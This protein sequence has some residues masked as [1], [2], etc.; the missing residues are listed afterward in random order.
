[1]G[2]NV[3]L[4]DY[5]VGAGFQVEANREGGT[6]NEGPDFVSLASL[7]TSSAH[8]DGARLL[9]GAGVEGGVAGGGEGDRSALGKILG[10][11]LE[12]DEIDRADGFE[13]GLGG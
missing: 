6:Y 4:K 13:T 8:V 2:I 3:R 9:K 7:A 5:Y 1:M 11:V 10:L 12:D